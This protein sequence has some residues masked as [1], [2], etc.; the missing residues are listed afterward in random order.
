MR[1]YL[2]IIL[3]V[4]STLKFSPAEE[5]RLLSYNVRHATDMD[6]KKA[7]DR[8]ADIINKTRAD[9]VGL[10]E[11]DE[12]CS[13]SGSI[14]QAA[15][16]ARR[17]GTTAH[18]GSFMDFGGGR[19]GMAM[20]SKLKVIKSEVVRLPEGREPRVAV[21]L[22]VETPGKNRLLVANVHFDW[23]SENLRQPQAKTLIEY[24]DKQDLPTVV[25]GD[26]N[27]TPDSA[28]IDLFRKA[29]FRFIEKATDKRLTWNARKPSVEIDH[30]AIRDGTRATIKAGSI[31]VLP[32][33]E[34]SD[35]R[36]V[37]ATIQILAKN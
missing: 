20:L 3:L 14:D 26:Y 25:L 13:R 1:N 23:T 29:G 18:F 32:E 7:M 24:L 28:T 21:V 6:G 5:L 31:E 16:F 10:Q 35:H 8:Q 17:T 33:A 2:I 36:P 12:K 19:Y 15:E 11:I 27:A 37:L 4:F 30:I 22:L 34:A 9:I